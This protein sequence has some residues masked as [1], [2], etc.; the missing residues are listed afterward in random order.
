MCLGVSKG[1]D[2]DEIKKPI[3]KWLLNITPI[4]TRAIKQLKK[5]LKKL[6]KL[7]KY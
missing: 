6:L 2:A 7:T 1:A 4:K 3:V 5:S